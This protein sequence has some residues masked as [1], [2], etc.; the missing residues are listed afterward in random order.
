[1]LDTGISH[2]DGPNSHSRCLWGGDLLNASRLVLGRGRLAPA[3]K[4]LIP[5]RP[6]ERD[7]IEEIKRIE[8][9]QHRHDARIAKAQLVRDKI[10]ALAREHKRSAFQSRLNANTILCEPF[11]ELPPVLQPPNAITYIEK[12]LYTGEY[13]DMNS[14]EL[15]VVQEIAAKDNV[16]WWHRIK[17]RKGFGINGFIKANNMGAPLAYLRTECTMLWLQAFLYFF[18]AVAMYRRNLMRIK[19]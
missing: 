5:H 14:D 11:Y 3:E 2:R 16:R 8:D 9:N 15:K 17:D 4:L 18:V 13:D 6:L 1:M 19:D 7:D 10:D 12:S